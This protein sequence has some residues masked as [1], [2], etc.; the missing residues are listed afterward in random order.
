MNMKHIA[1]LMLIVGGA[2]FAVAYGTGYIEAKK[3]NTITPTLPSWYT[4]TIGKIDGIAPT[5]GTF[6]W[7]AI[8]GAGLLIASKYGKV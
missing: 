3:Q 1:K 2:G 5:P 6:G 8:V 7:A 4:S